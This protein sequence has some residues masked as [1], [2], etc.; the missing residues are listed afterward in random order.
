MDTAAMKCN[1]KLYGRPWKPAFGLWHPK[2][3]AGEARAGSLSAATYS[4]VS[5]VDQYR[6]ALQ[7]VIYYR[8]C[9]LR[10]QGSLARLSAVN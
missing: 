1:S 5:R 4:R 7:P 2:P 8:M 6:T 3:S 9:T 10:T